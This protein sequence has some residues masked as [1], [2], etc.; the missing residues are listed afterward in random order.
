MKLS[1]CVCVCVCVCVLSLFSGVPLFTALW[2]AARQAPL[3]V[4][5]SRKEYWS[6]FLCPP[7]GDLPNSGIETRSP[8]SPALKADCSPLSNQ[9]SLSLSLGL[10]KPRDFPGAGGWKSIYMHVHT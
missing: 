4:G 2:P 7:P 1:L 10:I 6:R 8:T 5:F 9:G 3:P